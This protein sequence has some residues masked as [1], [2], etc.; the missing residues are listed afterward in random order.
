MEERWGGGEKRCTL[1]GINESTLLTVLLLVQR[2]FLGA[3]LGGQRRLSR[4]TTNAVASDEVTRPF[5][6]KN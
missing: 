2:S 5:V 1:Q 6:G 4:D 3:T